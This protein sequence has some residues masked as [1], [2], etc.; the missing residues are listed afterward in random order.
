[1]TDKKDPTIGDVM[2]RAED[3]V[4]GLVGMA[5]ATVG[6][7]SEKLFM[8]QAR[9]SD[10]Y[11]IEAAEVALRRSSSEHV[12]MFANTMV[13]DHRN[14]IQQMSKAMTGQGGEAALPS[15]LDARRRAMIDNLRN[16][17]DGKFD[18][19]YISQQQAAHRE[20]LTLFEGFAKSHQGSALGAF[21]AGAVPVLQQHASLLDAT[22]SGL[23]EA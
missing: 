16:V 15:E 17:S 9:I 6:G 2:R 21:A 13:E 14:S 11:E 20:A 12:R 3:A 19:T 8:Q 7:H 1:M 10:L 5:S 18:Q 4:G 22:A 23:A